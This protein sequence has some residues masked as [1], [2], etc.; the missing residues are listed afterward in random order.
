M[1]LEVMNWKRKI[2][3]KKGVLFIYL[4]KDISPKTGFYKGREVDCNI[5]VEN[6]KARII[7]D[8]I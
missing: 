8:P 4:A 6:G 5:V 1:R 2:Q 3:C 7:I